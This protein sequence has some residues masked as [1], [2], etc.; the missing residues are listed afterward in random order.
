MAKPGRNDPCHC[1]S[2]NKYKKCRLAKD[3]TVE[4]D[5][6]VKAQ[7]QHDKP[8]H[9]GRAAADR[10]HVAELTAA[11]AACQSSST[12]AGL[13]ASKP[14]QIDARNVTRR[15]RAGAAEGL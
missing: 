6:L 7:A 12:I 9:N 13:D 4:R 5:R 14:G 8:R 10:L 3:Q 1:G 11:V 15:G 2:G